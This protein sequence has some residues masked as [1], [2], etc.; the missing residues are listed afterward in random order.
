MSI[1]RAQPLCITLSYFVCRSHSIRLTCD[2]PSVLKGAGC[3]QWKRR[4][5]HAMDVLLTRRV[6]QQVNAVFGTNFKFDI[7]S[8]ISPV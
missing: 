4:N 1:P 2:V 7:A 3:I 8:G 5:R 6:G